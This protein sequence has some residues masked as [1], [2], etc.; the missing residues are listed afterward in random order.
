[1]TSSFDRFAEQARLGGGIVPVTREVVLDGE[2]PV[3]AF[4]KLHRAHSRPR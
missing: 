3:T 4:A 1:M 2:T